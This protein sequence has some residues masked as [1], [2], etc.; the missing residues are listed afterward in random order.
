MKFKGTFTYNTLLEFPIETVWG[1]FQSTE[2]L[3]NITSFPR[4]KVKGSSKVAEGQTVKLELNFG[5]WKTGWNSYFTQW[6]EKEVFEDII[7]EPCFPFSSWKHRHLFSSNSDSDTLMID[8]VKF[9]SPLPPLFIKAGLYIMFKD[10][11]RKI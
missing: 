4:I 9:E 10:R 5:I 3:V 7:V 2:N 6:K 11:K 8:I 1:F